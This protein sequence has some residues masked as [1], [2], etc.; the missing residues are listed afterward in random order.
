MVEAKEKEQIVVADPNEMHR[1]KKAAR[2]AA[3]REA[4]REAGSLYVNRGESFRFDNGEGEV[5][6]PTGG[7]IRLT[8]PDRDV[9]VKCGH[10]LEGTTPEQ[11]KANLERAIRNAGYDPSDVLAGKVDTPSE[12][13]QAIAQD[14]HA[15]AEA[16]LDQDDY[17]AAVSVLAEAGVQPESKKKGVVMAALV[18]TFKL[19]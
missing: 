6:V 16:A 17:N 7:F 4:V 11:A 3:R 8:G 10:R 18:E 15:R 5:L 1:R 2:V 19:G 13:G 12:S 14:L 9:L